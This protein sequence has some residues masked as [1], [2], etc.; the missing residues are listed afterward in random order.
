MGYTGRYD[1]PHGPSPSQAGDITSSSSTLCIALAVKR[2]H[3]HTSLRLVMLEKSQSLGGL[4]L[5]H[6]PNIA[7]KLTTVITGLRT[8]KFKYLEMPMKNE[9]EKDIHKAKLS[10]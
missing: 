8:L 7:S 3:Y 1:R 6:L 4:Y 2:Y 10:S 9:R 5:L